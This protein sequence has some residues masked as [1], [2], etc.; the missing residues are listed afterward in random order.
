LTP[1]MHNNF[2]IASIMMVPAPQLDVLVSNIHI[3]SAET[4][5]RSLL[6][7]QLLEEGKAVTN[8][9]LFDVNSDV[10]KPASFSVIDQFGTALQQNPGLKVLIVGHTDNDGSASLNLDLSKKRA[11]A[12]KN[13]LS[14]HFSI[15][16]TRMQSDGKGAS[17]PVAPNSTEAGKAKNRRV[18]FVKL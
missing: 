3:A 14:S 6:V 4:D 9:I 13:Y 18:E 5:A 8:D 10:I 2:Y 15:D 16:A 11:A 12:V 7:K 17:V 1:A